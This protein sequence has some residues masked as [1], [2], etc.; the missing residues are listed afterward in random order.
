MLCL[1]WIYLSIYRQ[2]DIERER[3][4]VFW[5]LFILQN[6]YYGNL[7]K[8]LIF[9]TDANVLLSPMEHTLFKIQ[10]VLAI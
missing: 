6:S 3:D 4:L 2:T 9:S 7:K 5:S 10:S 8:G 1:V